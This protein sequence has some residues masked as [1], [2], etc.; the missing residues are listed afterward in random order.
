MKYKQ[1]FSVALRPIF[2]SWLPLTE[3]AITLFEHTISALTPV[4]E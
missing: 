4:D 1:I 2:G 3:F